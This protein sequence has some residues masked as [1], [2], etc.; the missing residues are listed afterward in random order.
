MDQSRSSRLPG[1]KNRAASSTQSESATANWKTDERQEW[2][3]NSE[4]SC[5]DAAGCGER[6]YTY[7][8]S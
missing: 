5:G 2:P 4:G 8:E 1:V 3:K 6:D 7:V